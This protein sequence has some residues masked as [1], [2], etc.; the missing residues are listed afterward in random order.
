[1]G[2]GTIGINPFFSDRNIM[3]RPAVAGS[4]VLDKYHWMLY[5]GDCHVPLLPRH[6]R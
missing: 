6:A 3:S 4:L 2:K 5:F 1:M